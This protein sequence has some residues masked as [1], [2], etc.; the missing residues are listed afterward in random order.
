MCSLHLTLLNSISPL[1]SLASLPFFL[2]YCYRSAVFESCVCK[3]VFFFMSSSYS[4]VLCCLLSSLLFSSLLF[5]SLLFSSLLFSSLLLFC[6]FVSSSF[7]S[8]P[9]SYFDHHEGGTGRW[10]EPHAKRRVEFCSHRVPNNFLD[11]I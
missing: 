10:E 11:S 3:S 4:S 2:F 5:S 6:L 9:R 1:L 7:H 8:M